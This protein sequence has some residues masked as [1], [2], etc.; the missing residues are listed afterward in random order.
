MHLLD[1]HILERLHDAAA[2]PTIARALGSPSV[3]ATLQSFR[4]AHAP[5]RLAKQAAAAL[6]QRVLGWERFEKAL[7]GPVPDLVNVVSWL[8]ELAS[9]DMSFG[10]FLLSLL[11]SESLLLRVSQLPIQ[12]PPVSPTALWSSTSL[13]SFPEFAAFLRAFVGLA[14]VVVVTC[15]AEY[16]AD[17]SSTGRIFAMLRL[18]QEVDGYREVSLSCLYLV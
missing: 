4:N 1:K 7:L 2:H 17:T 18:W 8:K 12:E 10:V 11:E 6:Q 13:A 14:Y 16:V 3:L 9:E 15:W 5:S